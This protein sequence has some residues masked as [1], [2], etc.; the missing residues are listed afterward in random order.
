M[1]SPDQWLLELSSTDEPR[2]GPIDLSK[3]TK[4][5]DI[6]FRWTSLSIKWVTTTLETITPQHQDLQRISIHVP[7]PWVHDQVKDLDRLLVQ[8]WDSH[9]IRTSVTC[10]I[11]E[12]QKREMRGWAGYMF[13][14]LTKRGIIDL[15]E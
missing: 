9:S 4:L 13:P 11:A 14:E 5:K 6:V 1:P 12:H 8:L 10:F 7:H 15:V 2:P 3:A